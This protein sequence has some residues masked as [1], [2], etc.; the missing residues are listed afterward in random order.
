MRFREKNTCF[1]PLKKYYLNRLAKG[2]LLLK[3][4]YL[5]RS[6]KGL[7]L[8]LKN[9]NAFLLEIYRCYFK[10]IIGAMDTTAV[11]RLDT[12]GPH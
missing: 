11:I 10:C 6:A 9:Y 1:I 2:L 3:K 4:Y 12:K 8:L 5:Y 7:L